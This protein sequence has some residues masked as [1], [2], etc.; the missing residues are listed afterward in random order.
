MAA[1]AREAERRSQELEEEVHRRS[2]AEDTLRQVQKIEAVGQLTGG[3]AHDFNNHLTIIM[4]NVDTMKRRLAAVEPDMPADRLAAKL[5]TP[6]DHAMQAARAAAQLTHRLLAFSRR[7]ALNPV[8]LDLNR[9]VSST[10]ELIQR[11]LGETI[12]V[13]TV[14]SAGLWATFADANQVENALIN[15]VLNARDAM[16]DGGRLTIETSN[17]Y[18]DEAYV[19]RFAD[20]HP[21]QYVLVSVADTGAGIPK[22]LLDRA[23]EPFFTTKRSGEGTGLGLAMVH[24]FIKQSGGHVRIYSEVGQGTTVKLYFPRLMAAET[25]AASPAGL[26]VKEPRFE[27]ARG[28]EV[29]LV[30]EDNEGVRRYA[31]RR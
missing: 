2:V 9:L 23:F 17:T 4:G 13:E 1:N 7:Q 14:L 28:G 25:P 21:G 29:V 8:Q 18:L 3:I 30:V 26:P 19:A 22:E 15:L 31:A 20:L 27:G 6:V 24:G 11:T 16:P 10:T 12:Q 5:E